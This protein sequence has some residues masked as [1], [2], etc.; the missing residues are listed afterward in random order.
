MFCPNCGNEI[1]DG[2]QFCGKCGCSTNGKVDNP[3]NTP[4]YNKQYNTAPHN[5]TP[6]VSHEDRFLPAFI[7]GLIGGIFGIFGGYCTT[8]CTCYSARSSNA[9]FFLIFCGSILGLIG[10]CLCLK[11]ALIGSIIE[12]AAAI[13]IIICAYGISGSEF[14]TILALLLFLA[15][16]I[17][18]I[19]FSVINRR[20]K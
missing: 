17:T 5:N 12:L 2:A 14:M 16:G 6:A 7:L 18:G 15:G 4:N 8:L 3:Q 9:A 1:P 10:A 11:K 20:K 13:M 19:I